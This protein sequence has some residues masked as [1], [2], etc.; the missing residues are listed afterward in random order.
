M[1]SQTDD[2]RKSSFPTTQWSLVQRACQTDAVGRREG[3]A[4][5]LQQYLPALRA[6]LVAGKHISP[7]RADDLVQGFVADKIIEQ[8]LL[9]HAQQGKGKFRSFLMATLNNYVISQHRV[10]AAAKRSPAEGF[11]VLD[12]HAVRL[13]GGDDPAEQFNTAWARQLIAEALRRM[14]AEC[15][16]SNR[17][18]LW[19]IFQG[20]VLRPAF[21]G[22]PAA[23]YTDLVRQL[24]LGSPLEACRLLTTAKRM[25]SRN[26]RSAAS[27]YAGA[28]GDTD[29]E[30]EDLRKTLAGIGAQIGRRLRI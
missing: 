4:V 14:Q 25:F 19:T 23:D 16:Q 28:E 18:D 7:E 13:E 29:D 20:R 1:S 11:A 24:G 2:S 15:T 5:L 12:E 30:I 9:D 21:E 3:L 8:H 27:E 6:Y 17:A 26:L 22:Q 10:D